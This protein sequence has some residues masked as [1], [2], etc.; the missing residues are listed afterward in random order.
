MTDGN[1]ESPSSV[2]FTVQMA[3][4][5]V[6]LMFHPAAALVGSA[7][8]DELDLLLLAFTRDQSTVHLPVTD[9]LRSMA[10]SYLVNS[11]SLALVLALTPQGSAACS[12]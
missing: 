6:K 1:N 2:T 11:S 7:T 10:T 8:A 4:G 5:S 12:I 3:V 9:I